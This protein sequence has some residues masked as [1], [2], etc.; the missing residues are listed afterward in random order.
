VVLS[1]A[2]FEKNWPQYELDGLVEREMKGNA[3]SS[4]QCIISTT[5]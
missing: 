3:D 5:A 2:F 4:S 1:Q